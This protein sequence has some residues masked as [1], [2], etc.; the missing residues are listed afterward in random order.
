MILCGSGV[1]V[2]VERAGRFEDAIEFDEAVE[3]HALVHDV[4]AK[5]ME[6]IAV[7]KRIHWGASVGTPVQSSRS[8]SPDRNTLTLELGRVEP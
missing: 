7:V 6:V 3:I 8:T 5:D 2:E 1:L 4:L